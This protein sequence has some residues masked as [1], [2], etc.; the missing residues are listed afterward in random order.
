MGLKSMQAFTVLC[1]LSSATAFAT[2]CPNSCKCYTTDNGILAANCTEIPTQT[3]NDVWPQKILQIHFNSGHSA[4]IMLKNK[5]FKH[6]PRLTYLEIAGGTIRY[7]GSRAFDGLSELVELNLIGTGIR[8]LDRNTFIE[9]T[10]LTFLSL[11]KNVGIFMGPSFLISNSLNDLD[12]S[13]CGLKNLK[14]VYFDRLPNLKYLSVSKNKLTNLGY[15]FGPSNL[16]YANLAHNHIAFINEDL[17]SYKRL[18]TLILT[19]NPINCSCELVQ[20]DRKLAARGIDFGNTITCENN[21][22][23]LNDMVEACLD[24]DIMGDDPDVFKAEDLL[25]IDKN[26]LPA[27]DEL[28]DLGSGSGSGDGDLLVDLNKKYYSGTDSVQD[29][30]KIDT[31]A[32]PIIPQTIETLPKKTEAEDQLTQSTLLENSKNIQN[33][34]EDNDVLTALTENN[35]NVSSTS[36]IYIQPEIVLVPTTSPS[37]TL[38]EIEI[39]TEKT[40]SY[41]EVVN[42]SLLFSTAGEITTSSNPILTEIRKANKFPELTTETPS[43]TIDSNVGLGRGIVPQTIQAPEDEENMRTKVADYL[44]SNT[45]ITATAAI[46]AILI[47]AIVYKAVCSGFKRN[48]CPINNEK[49][50]E[51]KEIKYMPAD[52]EDLHNRSDDSPSGS[53][54]EN[55][56]EDHDSDDDYSISEDVSQSRK[57]PTEKSLTPS[58]FDDEKRHD[59]PITIFPT[60]QDGPTKVIVKLIETPKAQKPI[61]INNFTGV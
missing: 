26:A 42:N 54:E 27:S 28:E 19:G 22:R 23:P 39:V 21:G 18:R 13:E 15:Q 6:F 44:K 30:N 45:G 20:K 24:K 59:E 57:S 29:N 51:L 37:P 52:T 60:N 34:I 7:V 3:S 1:I 43:S 53:V 58:T 12:L 10:K 56:I 61:C 16:K 33:K 8:K 36:E 4:P 49:N 47:I 40:N 41:S 17:E 48:N 46:M 35:M 38:K 25:K 31:T 5:A 9:N 55:L 11:K 32:L 14:N 50:V 2:S